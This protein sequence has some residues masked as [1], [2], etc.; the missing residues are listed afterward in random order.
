MSIKRSESDHPIEITLPIHVLLNADRAQV[1]AQVQ[2]APFELKRT[3]IICKCHQ[4]Y[5]I[6]VKI[7]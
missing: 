5:K 6:F 7:I 4:I 3:D 2:K 1:Y